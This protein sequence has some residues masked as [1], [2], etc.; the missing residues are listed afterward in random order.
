MRDD[1]IK[2]HFIQTLNMTE[3]KVRLINKTHLNGIWLE[4]HAGNIK[5]QW[6]LDTSSQAVFISHTT[7]DWLKTRFGKNIHKNANQ[8]GQFRCFNNKKIHIQSNV[9]LK[10]YIRKNSAKNCDILSIRQNTINLLGRDVLQNL[11]MELSPKVRDGKVIDKFLAHL[12]LFGSIKK[13]HSNINI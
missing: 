9:N 11:E 6:L 3:T 8:V 12:N 7:T 4:T 5:L 13:P 10:P 1:W 2:V